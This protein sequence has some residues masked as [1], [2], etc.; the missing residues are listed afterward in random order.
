VA[1]VALA[2]RPNVADDPVTLYGTIASLG[3][4][5]LVLTFLVS[6]GFLLGTMF[7]GALVA[8][9]VLVF[10]WC[11]INLVFNTFALEEFSPISLNQR[12]PK[13]LR[14]PWHGTGTA[15]DR[16][17]PARDE[18]DD[19][20]AQMVARWLGLSSGQ[21][22]LPS[23]KQQPQFYQREGFREFS[24]V[25]VLLGYGIPTLLSVGLAAVWFSRRDL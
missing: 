8:M 24:L 10:V 21:S 13:L 17:Q 20:G 19:A 7:R 15:P 3:L 12:M 4:V 23:P 1:L 5:G 25:R 18:E 14:Q 11:P 16:Q 9:V 6:L 2:K 22:P